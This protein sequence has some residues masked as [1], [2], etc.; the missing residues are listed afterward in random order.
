MEFFADRLTSMLEKFSV[1]PG[2]TGL[3]Q[4]EGR[5]TTGYRQMVEK[6]IEYAKKLS[7]TLD[8]KILWKTIFV[9]FQT[10]KAC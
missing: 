8:L 4:V 2:I 10:K 7:W 5:S 1:K 6:D 3:W 9:V